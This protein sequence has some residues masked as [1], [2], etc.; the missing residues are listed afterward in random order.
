MRTRL[1][2]GLALLLTLAAGAPARAA[3]PLTFCLDENVPPWSIHRGD[4]NNNGFDYAVAAAVAKRLGRP[5]AVQWFE[6][7]LDEDASTTL[8]ANAL[9]SDGKCQLLGSYPLLRDALG[10]P[11]A[12]TAKLPD[13]EGATRAD[14]GRRVALG[15]LVPTRPYHRAV[16]TVVLGRGAAGK[17]IASL[18]DLAGLKLGVEAGTLTDAVL[19]SYDGGRLVDQITHVVPGREDVLGRLEHGD[20]DAVFVE[21]RRLDAYRAKHPETALAPSGYYY[22]VG[23]NMGFV[24]LA[25]ETSLIEQVNGVIADMLAKGELAPL[26]QAAGMTY[27]PPSSPDVLEHLT[28]SDLGN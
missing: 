25:G 12:A 21:L 16:F 20:F 23:F 9:M 14:R 27:V 28:M 10:K 8:A 17:P 3:E 15:T 19:M 13:F 26:A 4:G 7:K 5:F 11:G 22:R 2:T 6:S 18:A 24:G 1:A